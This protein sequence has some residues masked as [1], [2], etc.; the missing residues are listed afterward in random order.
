MGEERNSRKERK[1]E[2]GNLQ[3]TDVL[4]EKRRKT[5]ELR[6]K[7]RKTDELR[8][9]RRKTDELRENESITVNGRR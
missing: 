9:K 6:E 2:G 4:R 3:E 8:E 5:D 7:R 1:S